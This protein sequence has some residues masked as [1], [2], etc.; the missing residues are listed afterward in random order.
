M[1]SYRSLLDHVLV[2]LVKQLSQPV[3]AMRPCSK[4]CAYDSSNDLAMSKGVAIIG[5]IVSCQHAYQKQH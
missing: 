3:Q 5:A 2:L 1:T 4:G